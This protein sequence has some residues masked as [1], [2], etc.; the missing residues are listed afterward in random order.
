VTVEQAQEAPEVVLGTFLVNSEPASVLFNSGASHSFVTNQFVEKHNLPMSLMKTPLLV[1]SPGGEMKASH[2]CLRV[3][4]KLNEIE[5]LAA[6]VDL[7][8][9]GI[10]VILG[11]DWLRKHD[12]VIQCRK[13]S[14]VLTSPQGN[15]IEFKVDNSSEEQGTVNSAKGKSLE[16]IKVVN[17]YPDVFPDELPGMPPDRDIEFSIELIPGTA[18]IYKRP[19][20]MN[21]KDLAELKKQIDDLLSKGYIRPSSS[22]WGSPILFVDKK[23][24]TRR[25]CIDYRPLNDVTIKNKYPLPRIGDLFDQMKSAKILLLTVYFG[26]PSM[27]ITLW[28]GFDY[29]TNPPLGTLII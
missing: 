13:R 24:A 8:S 16:E 28:F 23:D 22:P 27:F 1:S 29:G 19:Y 15:R 3:N 10:D 14:V 4:L 21:V 9:W 17:E 5:F 20:G 26:T 7:K 11:M 6:L 2:I 25:M 18:P 12:G